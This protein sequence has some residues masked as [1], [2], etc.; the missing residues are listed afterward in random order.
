MASIAAATTDVV[1]AERGGGNPARVALSA[2]TCSWEVNAAGML[3][4]RMGGAEARA[5]GL[6]D[7]LRGRWLDYAHPLAGN[8]G[9]FVTAVTRTEDG[10]VEITAEGW[11]AALRGRLAGSAIGDPVAVTGTAGT[12]LRRL[13]AQAAA[14]GP[15]WLRAGVIE[16]AGPALAVEW[17]ADDCYE[18]ALPMLAAEAGNEARGNADRTVDFGRRVGRDLSGS[19]RL[20]DQGDD[21][22]VAAFRLT[23]DLWLASNVLSAVGAVAVR[24]R[25]SGQKA[26]PREFRAYV[27]PQ[28]AVRSD[29]ASVGRWGPLVSVREYPGVVS[30][31]ALGE[32]LRRDLA[33]AANPPATAELTLAAVGT[34]WLGWREGDT[35]RLE[36]G[37]ARWAGTLR[38]MGRT[39]DADRGVLTVVG[40]AREEQAA[41]RSYVV[42]ADGRR[43][44]DA[45]GQAVVSERGG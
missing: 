40:E 35:V 5:V 13:M 26:R 23:D 29:A 17:G 39:L 37:A 14:P 9:G 7:D 19:V 44:A 1:I 41:A 15:T 11:L 20:D 43:V 24:R 38:V 3:T 28:E 4:G 10:F 45:R 18:S 12:L 25:V 36:L 31:T 33:E 21:A 6:P 8:W 32:L 34:N 22:D 42:L 27:F 16:E 30:P 2:L